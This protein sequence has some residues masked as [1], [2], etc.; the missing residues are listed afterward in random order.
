M[1]WFLCLT[2]LTAMASVPIYRIFG[3]S[4]RYRSRL[5]CQHFS[6]SFNLLNQSSTNQF[7]SSDSKEKFRIY[8]RT[9]DSGTSG[10]FSGERRP[11][12][13][14]IFE[15]LGTT[16]ELT[17]C[18]GFAREFIN[19]P[20]ILDELEQIQCILQDLQATV[21]TPKSSS[22]EF[23]IR[24]TKWNVNHLIDLEKW[25]EVH[26]A[27][28]PPL[29]NFIL[30][31]GGKA[32]SSLHL[33]RAICRRAERRLIPLLDEGLELPVVQYLNRLSS[34]LFIVARVCCQQEGHKEVVYWERPKYN[35]QDDD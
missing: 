4:I 3:S 24:K 6:S 20:V 31:S 33:A 13:D 9:G 21:A 8:T 11:K 2:T 17:S 23:Q 25:L 10:L 26:T 5:L 15:A 34:Y 27:K 7:S 32:A 22:N 16:D 29:R 19:D 28:L 30:P 14:A 1:F 12:D 35:S 18:I